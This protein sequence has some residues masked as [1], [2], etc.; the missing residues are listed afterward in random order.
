MMTNDAFLIYTRGTL[1]AR[2]WKCGRGYNFWPIGAPCLTLVSRERVGG[3]LLTFTAYLLLF[4]EAGENKIPIDV[5]MKWARVLSASFYFPEG[6]S[7]YVRREDVICIFSSRQS[8]FF[9]QTIFS[10]H[11]TTV[12]QIQVLAENAWW[13]FVTFYEPYIT[14]VWI[15]VYTC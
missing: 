10:H 5:Q 12:G 6:F 15:H 8:T 3:L 9:S 2:A 1:G 11:S 7:A 4:G 14:A 13:N